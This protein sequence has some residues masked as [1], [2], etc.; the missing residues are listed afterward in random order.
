M[1][2]KYNEALELMAKE[3]FD[4][5]ITIFNEIFEYKDS[6]DKINE[7]KRLKNEQA[8]LQAIEKYNEGAYLEVISL[9]NN[10]NDVDGAKDLRSEACAAEAKAYYAIGKYEQALEYYCEYSTSDQLYKDICES[11]IKHLLSM[12]SY[13]LANSYAEKIAK[14]YPDIMNL[15]E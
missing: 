4:G 12:D 2:D 6:K 8:Y 5:A 10:V 9:L 14:T 11:L 3:D 7:C 13:E 1:G 15:F